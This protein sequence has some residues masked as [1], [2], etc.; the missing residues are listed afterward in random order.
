MGET[1]FRVRVLLDADPEIRVRV[2]IFSYYRNKLL[3][4]ECL[5]PG[6]EAFKQK[7][8]VHVDIFAG[9]GPGTGSTGPGTGPTGST[10]PGTGSTGEKLNGKAKVSSLKH[11]TIA[12]QN[13]LLP[14]SDA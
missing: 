10:G 1:L 5:G 13:R 2:E 11:C 6:T 7:L 9:A 14:R 4:L 12:S 8:H 3:K